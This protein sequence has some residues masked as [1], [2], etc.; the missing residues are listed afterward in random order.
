M[1]SLPVIAVLA[2]SLAVPA[3]AQ[4]SV[5][6]PHASSVDV[7]GKQG[8]VKVDPT[9]VQDYLGHYLLSN[10]KTMRVSLYR[11]RMY[12]HVAG[13]AREEIVPLAS[14]QFVA[15]ASGARLQFAELYGNPT[16]ELTMTLTV[17][18]ERIRLG[19]R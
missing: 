9:Q 18:V 8:R 6:L 7:V 17:P 12:M 3:I 19:S 16:N 4:Q 10:G 2:A 11:K 15:V 14:N 13:D 1:H 5:I